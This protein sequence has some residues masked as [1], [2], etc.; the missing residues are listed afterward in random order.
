M[1][2]EE[3]KLM[4]DEELKEKLNQLET[5]EGEK[6]AEVKKIEENLGETIYLFLDKIKWI[7]GLKIKLTKPWIGLNYDYSLDRYNWKITIDVYFLTTNSS[8]IQKGYDYDF[9]SNFTLYIKEEGI[10]I[11]H[12]TIG[13]YNRDNI[14]QLSRDML[15]P[16][17]WMKEKELLKIVKENIHYDRYLELNKIGNDIHKIE[18]LIRDRELEKIRNEY[19]EKIKDSNYLACWRRGVKNQRWD[20]EKLEWINEGVV[21]YYYNYEIIHKVTNKSVITYDFMF[22]EKHIHKIDVIID[23][24][25]SDEHFVLMKEKIEEE[26][27]VEE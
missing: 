16:Q 22:N 27:L 12:G 9:G 20:D 19:I 6:K 13:S 5:L 15:I 14:G 10:E 23:R 1:T 7:E 26:A 8:R 21:K 4:S 2:R 3:L 24:L 25:K 11:N 17:L 18:S